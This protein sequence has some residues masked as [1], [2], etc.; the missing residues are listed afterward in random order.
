MSKSIRES[1]KEL[2]GRDI[3]D[4]EIQRLMAGASA[5]G[6]RNDDPMIMLL[7]LLEHYNGLY[8][9]Q[10][11]RIKNVA[12]KTL[13]NIKETADAMTKQSVAEAQ[14]SMAKAIENTQKEL[15]KS[16]ADATVKVAKSVAH[17]RSAAL[18]GGSV[19]TCAVSA[20]LLMLVCLTV[21]EKNGFVKGYEQAK[22]EKAAY[23]WSN[24]KNG[25]LAY[26]LDL[27]NPT[28]IPKIAGC[29]SDGWREE[30]RGGIVMCYPHAVGN[31]IYGWQIR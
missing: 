18:I 21:G 28:T 3:T 24:T 26:Q 5:L 25:K 10:P 23:A 29:S 9:K 1:F 15:T 30:K 17:G 31:D 7:M 8:S 13:A 12:E 6:V 14:A 4:V 16:V 11:E 22:E 19:I 27:I 20:I 2:T